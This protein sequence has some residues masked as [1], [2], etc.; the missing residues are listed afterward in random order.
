M[1]LE[2]YK[3]SVV[4][5]TLSVSEDSPLDNLHHPSN[6][7]Y[8]I[9]RAQ[10]HNIIMHLTTCTLTL[11]RTKIITIEVIGLHTV[12]T[13]SSSHQAGRVEPPLSLSSAALVCLLAVSWPRQSLWSVLW[14]RGFLAYRWSC[15]EGQCMS[16]AR[17]SHLSCT[18]STRSEKMIKIMQ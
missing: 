13:C 1:L 7:R 9:H 11:M 12:A 18:A 16:D 14:W 10:T 3:L 8:L 6:Y 17:E 2:V 15:R 4:N 5:M